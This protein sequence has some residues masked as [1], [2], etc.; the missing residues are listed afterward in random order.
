MKTI[1]SKRSRQQYAG[2]SGCQK[3]CFAKKS[4]TKVLGRLFRKGGRFQ[5]QSLW[6]RPV[7][8]EIL[9][10]HKDQEGRRNSPVG[11]CVVGNPIKGFP[12]AAYHAAFVQLAI[13]QPVFRHAAEPATICRLLTNT[14]K[15]AL[16][17]TFLFLC[18][19]C[20]PAILGRRRTINSGKAPVK[21][22]DAV[23]PAFKCHLC[24]RFPGGSQ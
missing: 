12:D 13:C 6:S 8:R 23:E 3:S 19:F 11:C 15:S 24:R 1:E 7:G 14:V 17:S 2:S 18:A 20:L 9:C 10:F 16:I 5:R 4:C 21:I 22:G